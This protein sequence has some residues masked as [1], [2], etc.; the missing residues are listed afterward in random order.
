MRRK[1]QMSKVLESYLRHEKAIKKYLY[2]YFSRPQDVDDVAQ[3][4][5]IK[6][7]ATEARTKVRYPKRLLF[8]AAKHAALTE[9]A[10]R[11][12][13][14]FD[15]L[16]DFGGDDNTLDEVGN[17]AE[18]IWDGRRKLNALTIAISELPPVCRKV[19]ILRKIEGLPIKEIAARLEISVS[20]VEK[21]GAQGLIKCSRRMRELGYDPH[22]FGAIKIK[23][24]GVINR[25][26][27][28]REAKVT[29][30]HE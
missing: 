29:P 26:N 20:S 6:V 22:E 24:G 10:K 9:L 8:R 30:D 25:K 15:Y 3:E 5:F 1:S 19:F 16:E 14:D 2:R 21:H 11:K 12:S 27:S 28:F 7:F 13:K 18:E 17:N 23:E 4:A